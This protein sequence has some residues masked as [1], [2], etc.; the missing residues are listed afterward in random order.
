MRN[1]D[2]Y[3]RGLAPAILLQGPPGLIGS[4]H[5]LATQAQRVA[6]GGTYGGE[7]DIGYRA[8]RA[9]GLSSGDA[10]D[11]VERADRYFMGSLC[12]GLDTPTTYPGN[13]AK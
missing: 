5:Y 7:R 1:I 6:G 4:Q 8:L 13:R 9:A 10:M 12:L 2:G 11:A 3:S